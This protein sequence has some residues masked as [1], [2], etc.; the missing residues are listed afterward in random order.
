MALTGPFVTR[1]SP[2]WYDYAERFMGISGQAEDLHSV[3]GWSVSPPDGD[4]GS[5]EAHETAGRGR[6]PLI[7]CMTIGRCAVLTE[8][9]NGRAACHYCGT[10]ERGCT[11][12]SYFSSVSVALPAAAATGNMTL[13]PKFNRA[14]RHS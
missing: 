5:R 12:K 9:H 2:P 14:Q 10:C 3:A 1:T 7:A 4:D 8:V 6:F 11:T 13:I